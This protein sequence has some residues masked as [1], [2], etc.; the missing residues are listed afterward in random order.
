MSK[1]SD[2]KENLAT[3][4]AKRRSYTKP[5]VSLVVFLAVVALGYK[6]WENPQLLHQTKEMLFKSEP[7]AD[8]YQPQIDTLM[9]QVKNLQAELSMVRGRAENPDFSEMNKRIDD[10]EQINLNTIKS[11]ADVESVLGLVMR[12][13][14]A[15]GKIDDLAKV[16]NKGALTIMSAMLVKDAAER[17][18]EFV[19]EAEVLSE[20]VKGNAKVSKEL[21][22]IK[23][24]AVTGIPTKE[25]LQNKFAD[26]YAEKYAKVAE[27]I[28]PKDWRERIY[29]QIG[30]IIKIKK[31]DEAKVSFSEE[32]RAWSV[33]SDFIN[34][35]E[36][37][38]ATAIAK[39]PLNEDMLKDEK[40]MA[41]LDVAEVY[42][43]F[44]DAI[45]R[46]SA[47]TLAVMKVEFLNNNK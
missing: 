44:Y 2:K 12:M 42:N 32:D 22:L 30:K 23:N 1:D 43:N 16:T 13:D 37:K 7:K 39:K 11:K 27:E 33:V 40:F 17:G 45:S 47:N 38:R 21:E 10:L 28:A 24:I 25:E 36:I 26:I 46:I 8:I 5:L 3:I 20:I 41:W 4:K 29:Q 6:L 31:A 19:Y 9:Q 18:G 15:E 14:K 35:G 34:K